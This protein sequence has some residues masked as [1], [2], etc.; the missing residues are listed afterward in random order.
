MVDT[1]QETRLRWFRCGDEKCKGPLRRCKR[2]DIDI[3]HIVDMRKGQVKGRQ[4]KY[5]G[6]VI[7]QDMTQLRD[8]N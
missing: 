6:E 4:M 8:Q 5:W 2:L 1:T 3:R 7:R